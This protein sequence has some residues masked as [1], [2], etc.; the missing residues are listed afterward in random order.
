M[1]DGPSA[2]IANTMSHGQ[3]K[4]SKMS[5][6]SA[7]RAALLCCT[8]LA[9]GP[10]Q[11]RAIETERTLSQLIQ[12]QW[13]TEHGLPQNAIHCMAQ[14]H[15]GFI[16]IG[17]ESGLVR[18]D[19]VKFEAF[20]EQSDPP[21][22]HNFASSLLVARDGTVWA[23]TRTGGLWKY[24]NAKFEIPSPEFNTAHVY[25]LAE[26]TNG[27][28]FAATSDGLLSWDGT[29]VK[30]FGREAGLSNDHLTAIHA[31]PD[32]AMMVGTIGGQ[33]YRF[34]SDR[35]TNL[36]A[37][38][39]KA[40]LP[41]KA[42]LCD[43]ATQTLW[44]GH[45]GAG[46]YSYSFAT[47]EL[48]RA[49]LG[50]PKEMEFIYAIEVDSQ[51]ALWAGTQGQGAFRLK[52]GKTEHLPATK[53]FPD[54]E[55][56]SL[57]KDK[58]GSI[59]IGTHFSGLHRLSSGKAITV[60]EEAGLTVPTVTCVV[61][62]DAETLWVGTRGGGL[63]KFSHCAF[64]PV[65]LEATP[66]HPRLDV[67]TLL[68]SSSGELWVGTHGGG[69]GR[70]NRKGELQ[71]FTNADG[72]TENMIA[73]LTEVDGDIWIGTVKQG[74]CIYRKATG[75]I[76][77]LNGP[78]FLRTHLRS[79][80]HDPDGGIW[81]GTQNGLVH[82]AN[83]QFKEVQLPG[84]PDISL[85]HV[86]CEND[87]TLWLGTRDHGLLRVKHGKVTHYTK[88]LVHHRVYQI[89]P[90]ADDLYLAG[91]QGIERISRAELNS[92]AEGREKRLNTRLYTKR[93]GL[94]TS[95]AGG[96]SSPSA[97]AASNGG[98]WFGTRDGLTHLPANSEKAPEPNVVVRSVTVDS[99]K[100]DPIF[101]KALKPGDT[102][103]HFDYTA[104]SLRNPPNV[105]FRHKLDKMDAEWVEAGRRR[106]AVYYNLKPGS[107]V[108]RVTACNDEGVWSK[109]GATLAFTVFPTVY[110][111]VWFRAFAIIASVSALIGGYRWRVR[112][113]R[114][115]NKILQT[116]VGERTAEL[117][118]EVNQR[119]A[120]EQQLRVLNEEL[121]SR[122]KARTAEVRRAY[123]NL[124]IELHERQEAERALARS[125]ARLRRMVDSGMVGIL[126][127]HRSG[128][129]TEANETFLRMVGYSRADLEA[130]LVSWNKLTP[131]E[132]LSL[133]AAALAEIKCTGVCT[134]FEKE[135][136][137]KDG[138]RVPIL[139]GGASLGEDSDKGVCFVLDI[140]KLKETEEEIR[141]LNL[142]LEARVQERTVELAHTNEQLAAEVQERKRVAVA[143]YAFSHL[144]QKLHSARTEIEAA[145]IVADTAKSLIEHD[146]CSIELYDADGQLSPVLHSADNESTG[147]GRPLACNMS[148]PIRNGSRVVGVIGLTNSKGNNFDPSD[149]STLQALGDYCGGAL[150]RIHAETARRE[151]ERRFATFMTNAPALAWMKD[152]QFRYV[153]TNAMFQRFIG[154]ET[155][156]IEGKTDYDLWPDH[157]AFD[158]RTNDAR[159]VETQAKLETHDEL[160][161]HDGETRSLLTLRFLFT[162]AT[163]EQFVAGMAVDITEQKRAEEALHRL[164]QSILEAQEA[165]RR[166]VARE[167][168]DGVNQAIASIKFRIQTAEQQILRADPRW[169]ETCG[170]T[171]DM[172]DSVLQQVRRLSRNLRPGELDDFG[173]VPAARSACQEF[174]LRNGITVRFTHSDFAERLPA[175]LEL[176]LY[177]IIQEALTNVEKHSQASHVEI[178]L[179]GDDTGV[180]LEISDDG[181]GFEMGAKSGPDAGLGLLH[182]RERASLV[183]GVFSMKTAPG[184][185]VRLR[186]FAPIAQPAETAK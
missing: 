155:R 50:D 143:L 41:V 160:K 79:F 86:V 80:A 2:P 97:I 32:G 4:S 164:P 150:E 5:F 100:M 44:I 132:H 146:V 17:T 26:G 142:K 88:G 21:V 118:S 104:L 96:D 114:K 70:I 40:G 34:S 149:A 54:D 99:E 93:E 89:I 183:G 9:L 154:L 125:E 159:A 133:D 45:D 141:Q 72:L 63:F 27:T 176:S 168:H 23:G 10:V 47:K 178:Q 15:V 144:G 158:M 109:T 29:S 12:N 20:T 131:Q 90:T 6:A 182:M 37:H 57:L 148:V 147:T 119:T 172:L 1:C 13:Q 30:K 111:T 186:V 151:T 33:V 121:E 173:L 16:W 113:I 65:S 163:G 169:Q 46:L 76:E 74:I 157:V 153:F 185:G 181:S 82:Y 64:K 48:R 95:E 81:I 129:I 83:G 134:P 75:K 117:Q 127:W 25:G 24:R 130:G 123:E 135:Y 69:L 110:Q 116:L 180:T 103:L 84:M 126:F 140:S 53:Y 19:G 58:E 161:R 165:E 108:F 31:M 174:E 124:E 61:E 55:V 166:R 35:F 49:E 162:T 7:F 56:L 98:L 68:R 101:F 152:A 105:F 36:I 139:I 106:E 138:T 167:L 171:K 87:G 120:A 22:P 28:I 52:N 128:E 62:E 8:L 18:F 136:I 77:A 170:K 137:R 177:R 39:D 184:E 78:D 43:A 94:H 59:W 38:A 91:N 71:F 92:V 107:Y 42:L 66:G 60:G 179:H 122:V 85:R 102:R 156:D 51:G 175:G 145:Q 112:Q 11:V 3:F 73:S 14:D 115:R 67:R